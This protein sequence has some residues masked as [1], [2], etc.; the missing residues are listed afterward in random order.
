MAL[1]LYL[2]HCFVFNIYKKRGLSQ[3]NLFSNQVDCLLFNSGNEYR[4]FPLKFIRE[5]KHEIPVQHVGA[6][7]GIISFCHISGQRRIVIQDVKG[8]NSDFGSVLLEEFIP[9]SYIPD[10]VIGIADT[11][12][13]LVVIV[14]GIC[15]EHKI[16]EEYPVKTT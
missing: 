10:R 2:W 12:Q 16:L 5:L 8:L 3:I 4:Q 1:V 15:A 9:E 13:T 11:L 14:G 6:D 7:I